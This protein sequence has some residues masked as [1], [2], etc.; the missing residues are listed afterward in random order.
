MYTDPLW[1]LWHYDHKTNAEI[2]A[3]IEKYGNGHD[4]EEAQND[5]P[6]VGE[7]LELAK[8][9]P[10]ITFHGY[11]VEK[12]RTDFRVSI[13]G[14]EITGLTA[15]EALDVRGAYGYADEFTHEKQPDGTYTVY[16]WW[17]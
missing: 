16:T 15:D 9:Y 6:T 11:V 12:P 17:D 8:S 1:H 13:E 10:T 7:F 14:F 2:E 5:S 4:M 3:Y